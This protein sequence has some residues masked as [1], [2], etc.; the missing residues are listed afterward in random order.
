MK[1]LGLSPLLGDHVKNVGI[2]VKGVSKRIKVINFW[3]S[4]G[5]MSNFVSKVWHSFDTQVDGLI[6]A[7][8]LVRAGKMV[9]AGDIGCER[10]TQRGAFRPPSIKEQVLWPVSIE[11]V[12]FRVLGVWYA[13]EL[14]NL[15]VWDK[16]ESWPKHIKFDIFEMFESRLKACQTSQSHVKHSKRSLSLASPCG[17]DTRLT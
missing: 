6:R 15:I 14:A 5:F 11:A 3:V 13:F 9:R 8:N 4:S 12:L 1:T 10:V 16:F 2:Y 7:D 17:F